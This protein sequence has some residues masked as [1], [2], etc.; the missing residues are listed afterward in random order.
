MLIPHSRPR[1]K[2]D[3]FDQ[4]GEREVQL[5]KAFQ[6]LNFSKDVDSQELAPFARQLPGDGG[7]AFGE[8]MG[9]V[10]D[11]LDHENS[12]HKSFDDE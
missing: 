4:D 12:E 2:E 8:E 11:A 1:I 3:T 6:D 9:R 10:L 7:Q 5:K